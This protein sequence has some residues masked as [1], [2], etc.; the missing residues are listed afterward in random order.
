MNISNERLRNLC[1]KHQWFTEGTNGQYE[2][3]FYANAHGAPLEE[4]VSMIWMCSDIETWCRRE[5]LFLKVTVIIPIMNTKF[6]A[7][8]ASIISMAGMS[9]KWMR[10]FF[11]CYTR[12][13]NTG[14]D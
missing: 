11:G 1:I 7:S 2:K 12:I 10:F 3:L 5:R 14:S 4:I 9:W 8:I 6:G 13:L